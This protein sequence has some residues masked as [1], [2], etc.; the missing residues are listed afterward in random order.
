MRAKS[1]WQWWQKNDNERKK[2]LHLSMQIFFNCI[3]RT[4]FLHHSRQF[5][6]HNVC[7]T[8]K[9]DHSIVMTARE[10]SWHVTLCRANCGYP[11]YA[12]V[13]LD[14]VDDDGRTPHY[15][16]EYGMTEKLACDGW[17]RQL[18]YPYDPVEPHTSSIFF[19]FTFF[20]VVFVQFI[21]WMNT[22]RSH[23][24]SGFMSESASRRRL[25]EGGLWEGGKGSN[26]CCLEFREINKAKC[27]LGMDRNRLP[28]DMYC[29]G[30]MRRPDLEKEEAQSVD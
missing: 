20:C 23:D 18:W 13:V 21:L 27:N 14:D 6:R 17:S 3:C 2:T 28:S 10:Q 11:D 15:A 24:T 4:D 29:I 25:W 19:I 26:H 5:P 16:S 30:R 8:M 7:W 9:E 1:F 12:L 22:Q